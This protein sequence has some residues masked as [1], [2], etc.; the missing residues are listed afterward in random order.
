ML[1]R[2]EI[3]APCGNMS[4]LK[5]AIAAGADACYLAG[6]S[7]GARA[8]A[9]NFTSD[10]LL[11]AIEEAHLHNVKVYLTCNT[12]VKNSELGSVVEMLAPLY[13]AGLDAVLIQDLGIV[14]LVRETFPGL[15]IH[16]STQMNILTPAGMSL[17]KEM[18]ATRVVAAREMTL[19]EIRLLKESSDLEL[20]VFVH[21]AM[22]LCYSGRCLMSSMLGGRSGNRGRCAQPCRQKYNGK[23]LM[24]MRDLSSLKAVP[25]LIKAGVDSLKIE[26]RM[27]NEYYTAA[28]VDAYKTLRDAY[29]DGRYSEE[30]AVKYEERLLDIFNRGGFSTGYFYRD[31]LVDD[32]WDA[33]LIDSSMPGRRG[34]KVGSVRKIAGGKISFPADKDID[35]GDELLIDV[36]E[37]I[38]IT[39]NV[40]VKR[41]EMVTLKAPETRR[42]SRGAALYRTRS[43]TLTEYYEKLINRD[44]KL[45]ITGSVSAVCGERLT[46]K[47]RYGDISVIERG[48][49]VE[50][51]TNR[52]TNKETIKNKISQLG[53]TDFK[54]INL[55]SKVDSNVFVRI[56]DISEL[57][58]RAA[59]NLREAIA[60]RYKRDKNN[61]KRSAAF[62]SLKYDSQDQRK[63]TLFINN[64][65]F[66]SFAY[67][68][69]L[70]A[71]LNN[72][73]LELTAIS[74][75]VYIALDLGLGGYDKK[76]LRSLLGILND[77]KTNI[78]LNVRTLLALPYINRGEYSITNDYGDIIGK[79]DGLYI[80]NIDDLAV[81]KNGFLDKDFIIAS[82]LYT[83][84]DM[85]AAEI[86]D[87]LSDHTGPVIYETSLELTYKEAMDIEY[88]ADHIT[89]YYG[90]LP[91]MVT[92]G[93]R[94][95]TQ[96]LKDER[97][98]HYN[99]VNA[100]GLSYNVVFTDYPLSL[101]NLPQSDLVKKYYAFTDE[102]PEE[103]LDVISD[104]PAYIKN[105]RYTEG[106]SAKGI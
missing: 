76:T 100:R 68:E 59:E 46:L 87:L 57:R 40:S 18:G 30:L 19:G 8:Y 90:K 45:E 64:N 105:R 2:P 102:T 99:V 53:N 103:V 6:T 94:D 89:M 86:N 26:G 50:A 24:S 98:H 56:G 35:S 55:E 41:G 11:L 17:A 80:R 60:G 62:D 27:K 25:D 22:C 23:Y 5:A 14:K 43:R 88:R 70:K 63:N 21:G 54:L 82:S 104:S 85:A 52:P 73:P 77:I 34:V 58:R 71:F 72:Y 79:I 16:T 32:K 91:L 47:L 74:G 66:Y 67:P 75:Y 36:E 93:L 9:D 48:G 83:Y 33:E 44:N 7:F 31:R 106:H 20:E 84:N 92:S 81:C 12:L 42:I 65:R 61:I 95:T 29:I 1:R 69:Q 78:H 15:E 51:S 96:D 10:E 101:V 4:S 38:S 13:E 3:L 97:R 39:S 37:P 28:T 49:V